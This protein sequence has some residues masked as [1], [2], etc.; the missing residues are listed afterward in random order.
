MD[1]I[2]VLVKNKNRIFN[3][4][5]QGCFTKKGITYNEAYVRI[6]DMRIVKNKVD[7]AEEGDIVKSP[8]IMMVT[9][10]IY[11]N[12]EYANDYDIKQALHSE[13]IP[14]ICVDGTNYHEEAYKF[15]QKN[16]TYL[17][18]NNELISI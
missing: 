8:L 5:L 10:A 2:T 6:E 13:G 1:L 3:M 16:K 15:I 7:P 12:K 11:P 18:D 4:A 14:L 9:L 17:F